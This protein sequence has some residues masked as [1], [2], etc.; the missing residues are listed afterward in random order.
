M[1][2]QRDGFYDHE[3]YPV[4]YIEREGCGKGSGI[5]TE[6]GYPDM[7]EYPPE[8]IVRIGAACSCGW[9]SQ[10]FRPRIGEKPAEWMPH[11]V[12]LCHYDDELVHQLWDRHIANDCTKDTKPTSEPYMRLPPR[13]QSQHID[14]GC[15]ECIEHF[16]LTA[17]HRQ[18]IP[19]IKGG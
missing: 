18:R 17:F 14:D 1:G 4:A 13:W 8:A 9:R 2:I 10:V 16:G 6:L 12:L 3:G 11:I 7:R 15:R 19:T 5:F